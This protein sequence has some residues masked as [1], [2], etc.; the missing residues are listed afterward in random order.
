MD[1]FP[2]FPRITRF[3]R[4]WIVTEKVDG[5]NGLVSVGDDGSVRAGSRNRWLTASDDNFGFAAWVE[6]NA[7]ELRKLGPG[8][9]HGEWYG[10]GIQRG[11]GLSD[12]RFALFNVKRWHAFG[13]TSLLWESGNARLP[14]IAT[15]EAPAC[16]QVVPLLGVFENIYEI[17]EVIRLFRES[18]IVP[19]YERPEGAVI[20]HKPSGN[21]YK[22]T[23]G[24]DG[25]KGEAR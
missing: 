12:R 18:R 6:A 25:H 8:N 20:C 16:C 7:D 21:L 13:G 11:Y 3:Y 22:Y 23:F 10:R 15:T 17:A 2:S 9:H 19:G 14:P 24:G 5:T 1:E 4:N